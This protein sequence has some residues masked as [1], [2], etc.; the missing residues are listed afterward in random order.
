MSLVNIINIQVLDNPTLF[1]NP[2]HFEITF[3]CNAELKD[4]NYWISRLFD[5]ALSYITQMAPLRV[6][7]TVMDT[8]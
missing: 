4:G 5:N 6:Y 1:T 3:E 2:F 8:L 7:Y